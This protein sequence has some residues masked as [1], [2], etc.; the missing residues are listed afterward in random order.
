MSTLTPNM[1][2][3]VPGA[4]SGTDIIDDLCTRIA[5]QIAAGHDYHL[6]DA[7]L[8]SQGIQATIGILLWK[9]EVLV[10]WS[11]VRFSVANGKLN[12]S[13]AKNRKF[14]KSYSLRE[15]WNAVIFEQITKVLMS[16]RRSA[17]TVPPPIS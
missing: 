3:A 12:L 4:I 17:P 5:N 14:S 13:S 10:P 7:R 2:I 15:V 1:A 16:V 6:G 8:S 11:E 9:E